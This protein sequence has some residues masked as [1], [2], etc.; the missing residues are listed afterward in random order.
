[1]TISKEHKRVNNMQPIKLGYYGYPNKLNKQIKPIDSRKLIRSWSVNV[2]WV[3][4]NKIKSSFECKFGKFFEGDY[5]YVTSSRVD[6][7]DPHPDI[8]YKIENINN[9]GTMY[10]MKSTNSL[11]SNSIIYYKNIYSIKL[12]PKEKEL[13]WRIENNIGK[14]EF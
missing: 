2:E 9:D 13:S 14:E 7:S 5:I 8:I 10:L 4:R 12:V 6:Y 11:R 3:T 1:M